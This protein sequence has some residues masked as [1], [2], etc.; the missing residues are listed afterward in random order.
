MNDIYQK[1]IGEYYSPFKVKKLLEDLDK[2]I[3]KNNLQFVEH[4]VQEQIEEK[5]INIILNIY[6]GEKKLIERINVLGNSVTNEEVIRSEL[7]IDEGEPFSN[8]NLEKSIAQIKARNIFRKVDYEVLD[9]SIDNL[10]VI[11][12]KVE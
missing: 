3:D 12:I 6:E 5:S 1:Y 11:N 7:I 8:L 2:L 9:G 4:N 10:K